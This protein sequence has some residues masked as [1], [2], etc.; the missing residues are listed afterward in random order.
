MSEYKK[1]DKVEY[2]PIGGDSD[3]VSHS[4]GEVV[5]VQGSGAVSI[6]SV[7]PAHP[8]TFPQDAKYT[9]RN[10]NTGKATTYQEKNIVSKA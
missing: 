1:G 6:F 7:N 10:D 8:L 5:E 9:I 4:V 2:R 3:N